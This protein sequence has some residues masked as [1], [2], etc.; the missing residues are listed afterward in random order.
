MILNTAYVHDRTSTPVLNM[1][2]PMDMLLNKRTNNSRIK[3]FGSASYI[4]MHGETRKK[5]LDDSTERG[6]YLG[7]PNRICRIYNILKKRPSA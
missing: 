5:K 4:H 7:S 2:A 3:V 6:A 1:K